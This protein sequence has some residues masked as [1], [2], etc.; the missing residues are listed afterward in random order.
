MGGEDVTQVGKAAVER[1][2]AAEPLGHQHRDGAVD[3]RCTEA[4]ILGRKL[5]QGGSSAWRSS[6]WSSAVRS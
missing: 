3:H 1:G 4:A 2:A 5:R 6:H